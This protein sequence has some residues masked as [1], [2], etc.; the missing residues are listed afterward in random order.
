MEDLV[1]SFLT[2]MHLILVPVGC[3]RLRSASL[4]IWY[5]GYDVEDC[6]PKTMVGIWVHD[7]ESINPP[8]KWKQSLIYSLD[9]NLGLAIKVT[10]LAEIQGG[11]HFTSLSLSWV[12]ALFRFLLQFLSAYSSYSFL[13]PPSFYRLFK[14]PNLEVFKFTFNC[15]VISSMFSNLLSMASALPFT[16]HPLSCVS[17]LPL[18][19]LQAVPAGSEAANPSFALKW[20]KA[21]VSDSQFH[22]IADHSPR[23]FLETLWCTVNSKAQLTYSS[24]IKLKMSFS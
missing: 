4:L 13:L 8:K 15:R 9:E 22:W 20:M 14:C 16:P 19:S 3:H 23:P 6:F 10:L 18:L 17:L 12:Q 5:C 7:K 21:F 1:L 24:I 11:L 2:S